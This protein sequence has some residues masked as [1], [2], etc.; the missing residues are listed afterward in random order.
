M[1]LSSGLRA[2]EERNGAIWCTSLEEAMEVLRSIWVGA[3][4]ANAEESCVDSDGEDRPVRVG[5]VFVIGGQAVYKV[6]L[7]RPEIKRVLLTKIYGEW[8]CDVFFPTDIE[9]EKGWGRKGIQDFRNWVG[10][11]VP[12]GRVKEGDVEFEYFMF[13]RN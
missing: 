1:V 2:K 5:R 4:E 12:E 11:E 10:E 3:K 6:A 7:K 9:H 8:D 13:E